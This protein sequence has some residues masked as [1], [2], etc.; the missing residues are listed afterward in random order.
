MEERHAIFLRRLT[1]A[2]QNWAQSGNDPE[3]FEL[4]HRGAMEREVAHPA[5]NDSWPTPTHLDIDELEELGYVRV[6][7][8]SG[9]RRLF[10]LT[11]RGRSAGARLD[12]AVTF[13]VSA[14]GGRAPIPLKTLQWLLAA[15]EAEPGVLDVPSQILDRAV[16]EGVIEP[17][18]REALARRVRGLANEGLPHWHVH[19]P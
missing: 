12:E 17:D 11:V 14:G 2:F 1:Q 8:R 5:W 15:V 9:K 7:D 10:A 6:L 4:R 3:Q 16:A 19:G 13:P 18:G